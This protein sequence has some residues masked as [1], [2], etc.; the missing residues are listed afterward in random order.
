MVSTSNLAT[1]QVILFN[2]DEKFRD[3][4]VDASAHIYEGDFV[5]VNAGTGYARKLTAGDTFLGLAVRECYNIGS[6][7]DPARSGDGSAGSTTV[8][9]LTKGSIK[10]AVTD[11][12]GSLIPDL[13]DSGTTVAAS[14]DRTVTTTTGGNSTIGKLDHLDG[15]DWIINIEGTAERSI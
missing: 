10:L 5:G 4:E 2:G 9:V 13:T 6:G 8:R 11:G 1:G 12:A 3:Y 7:Y 14:D 15:D